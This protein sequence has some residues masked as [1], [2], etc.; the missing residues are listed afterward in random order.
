MSAAEAHE[1]EERRADE[2]AYAG[3]KMI[4]CIIGETLGKLGLA[5]ACSDFGARSVCH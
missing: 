2:L 4:S 1:E 3:D 5:K